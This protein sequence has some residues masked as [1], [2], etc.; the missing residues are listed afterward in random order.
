[1][2]WAPNDDKGIAMSKAEKVP[3][4]TELILYNGELGEKM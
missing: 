1:M 2:H 4:L 3:P